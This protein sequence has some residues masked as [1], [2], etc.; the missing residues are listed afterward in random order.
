MKWENVYIFIS[1]TFN[2][3][4]AE[5]DYLVKNV[6]PRLSEWCEARKLR[7]VDIDLRWGVSETDAT[8][9]KRAVQVC[10]T[11]IDEC[12]PFFLCFL[13]QRRGWVPK[14]S[15]ISKET[16]SLFPGLNDEHYTGNHSVTEMEILHALIDPLHHGI[17]RKTTTNEHSGKAVKYASFFFR[18]MDYLKELPHPDLKNVYTNS[19]DPDPETSDREL[20]YWREEKIPQTGKPLHSYAASWIKNESTPE[21]ALPLFVP[22]TAESSSETWKRAFEGWKKRWEQAGIKIDDSGEITDPDELAKAKEYNRNFTKGRLGNFV[23]EEKELARIIIDGLKEAISEHFPDHTIIDEQQSPL[24]KELDQQEQFLRLASE[25]FIERY[26]DLDEIKKY[27]RNEEVRP[28]AVTA[29]AGMGKTSLLAHFIDTFL[30]NGECNETIHYRFIGG[31]DNSANAEQLLRSLLNELKETGKISSNIPA[32][33]VEMHNQLPDLLEEAGRSGKTVLVIDAL[34]QLET[35]MTDLYWMLPCLPQNV[36]LVVSFK[37]G[38]EDAETYFRQQK[39]DDSMIFYHVRPFDSL[40]DRMMLVK[41]YLER[42]LKELDES[43]MQELISSEGANNPLFLKV[44]LSELRVFGVH[45]NLS[46]MIRHNFGNSPVSAFD[47]ILKRMENDPAYTKLTPAVALPHIFGWIAHSRYGLKIEELAGL[48]LHEKFTVDRDETHEL[49]QLILRQLRPFLARRDGRID[50]FYES[51]KTAATERYTGRHAYARSGK[52][53]HRSLSEYFETLPLEDQHKLNEQAWQ[54]AHAGMGDEYKQLLSDY[55]YI[56][57]KLQYAGMLSL[58]SD[59]DLVKHVSLILSE[60]DREVLNIIRSSLS[61]SHHILSDHEDQL[62][63]QLW[64]R[65][66]SFRQ[67][68][69]RNLLNQAEQLQR[70]VWIKPLNHFSQLIGGPIIKIFP[71]IESGIKCVGFMSDNK[72]VV[73][74]AYDDTVKAWDLESGR[75][76]K[77]RKGYPK[78]TSSGFPYNT[79]HHTLV[80]SPDAEQAIINECVK[81]DGE[82]LILWDVKNGRQVHKNTLQQFRIVSNAVFSPCGQFV[83]IESHIPNN[84]SERRIDLIDLK[85]DRVMNTVHGILPEKIQLNSHILVC[86]KQ[87]SRKQYDGYD[88]KTGRYLGSFH[89]KEDIIYE[90]ITLKDSVVVAYKLS[91]GSRFWIEVLNYSGELIHVL[92]NQENKSGNRPKMLIHPNGSLVV[93]Y[94][95]TIQL[96]HIRTEKCYKKIAVNR[97]VKSMAISPDG[98]YIVINGYDEICVWDTEIESD[99]KAA[100]RDP[101]EDLAVM[102]DNRTVVAISKEVLH[103]WDLNDYTCKAS[104]YTGTGLSLGRIYIPTGK[105]NLIIALSRYENNFAVALFDA[106]KKEKVYEIAEPQNAYINGSFISEMERAEERKKGRNFPMEWEKENSIERKKARNIISRVSI[107]QLPADM[108]CWHCSCLF[109]A[110]SPNRKFS[111]FGKASPLKNEDAVSLVNKYLEMD[112]FIATEAAMTKCY[113][114][115][116]V[117]LS[118]DRKLAIMC[119]DSFYHNSEQFV[120]LWDLQTNTPVHILNGHTMGVEKVILTADSRYAITVSR[121]HSLRVWDT[122]TGQCV[123]AFISDNAFVSVA[124]TEDYRKII[125]SDNMGNLL[126]FSLENLH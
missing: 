57:S 89:L 107:Y 69:I 82:K 30:P 123:T 121:D 49:I 1:S 6:F 81:H 55:S 61:L 14:T 44:A 70:T 40:I 120:V 51:F 126:F 72:T 47:A 29:Y 94:E 86:K 76:L 71:S 27:V 100:F 12:R 66:M 112:K 59:Y 33:A 114:L 18:D 41:A 37:L 116:S 2:D 11:R 50:F 85:N 125:A 24:Q 83:A 31:S 28:F 73:S 102:P 16:Y 20:K 97:F 65:L 63:G 19:S 90:I 60:E 4:H 124:A 9:N 105:K 75:C 78:A 98:R 95:N 88:I 45:S 5:R 36:K 21:I 15:E 79:L 54:Y 108:E 101:M 93:F 109:F 48:L 91:G 92:E 110:T 34:N 53:W 23:C 8:Q 87:D 119:A 64:G 74:I 7:L 10:L 77:T 96:I 115:H 106:D 56:R 3:M 99:G 80:L 43:R 122:K 58:I 104:M 22:T 32:D 62:A 46:E 13:G 118:N 35:G 39:Q 103:L 113:T 117:Y 26:G 84:H 68:G 17:L 25:G 42:Y 67:P 111:L 52:E 38:E